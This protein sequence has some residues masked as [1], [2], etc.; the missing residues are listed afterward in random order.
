MLLSKL[1]GS[2]SFSLLFL[3]ETESHLEFLKSEINS[4]FQF[5]RPFL[6]LMRCAI[7]YHLYNSKNVKNTY[8]RVLILVVA[9]FNEPH[10]E[11]TGSI[12]TSVKT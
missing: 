9:G 12:V 11:L 5:I 6:Y 1:L 3:D 8:G 10:T 4:E 2:K 7:C